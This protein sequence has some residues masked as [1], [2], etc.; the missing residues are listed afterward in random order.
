M[1]KLTN[2]AIENSL[3]LQPIK[4]MSVFNLNNKFSQW[5]ILLLLAFTWGSSFILMKRGLEVYDHFLVAALRISLTFIFLAPFAFFYLKKVKKKYWK[6]LLFSG[7]F[8]NGIPAFLFT[9]AQTNISSS[10]SGMLNS[11]TPIFAL[12]VGL[13][14][15]KQ[16][17]KKQQIIGVFIGLLGALSLILSNGLALN[18]AEVGYS[19]YVIL[20][21]ICPSD[22][23]RFSL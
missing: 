12:I 10:L 16:T 8:G 23:I 5:T 7:L 1:S 11:L 2:K 13:L 3:H 6:Y 20:A 17:V 19:F 4:K 9:I 14:I 21:T 15:F 22:V 18:N